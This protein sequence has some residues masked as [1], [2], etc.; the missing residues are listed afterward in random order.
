MRVIKRS[1][2][3]KAEAMMMILDNC[4]SSLN[5]EESNVSMKQMLHS[6][7]VAFYHRFILKKLRMK[8][9]T[10]PEERLWAQILAMA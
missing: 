7:I 5:V 8:L 2:V 4:K 9:L 3:P 1:G 10:E 6:F